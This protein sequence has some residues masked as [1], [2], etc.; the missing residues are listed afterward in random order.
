M[1][2]NMTYMTGLG[3][4]GL[5]IRL[6]YSVLQ[7]LNSIESYVRSLASLITSSTSIQIMG[8]RKGFFDVLKHGKARDLQS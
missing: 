6:S 5:N 4:V 8:C 2:E 7:G 3:T 1:K